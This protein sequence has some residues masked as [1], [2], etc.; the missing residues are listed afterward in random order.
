MT[1]AT[2]R[3][4]AGASNSSDTV[5]RFLRSRRGGLLAFVVLALVGWQVIAPLLESDSVPRPLETFAFM[6]DEIRGVT[7]APDNLYQ[8]FLITMRR[9]VIGFVIAVVIGVPIGLLMGLSR[10]FEA[11]FRDL[12]VILLTLPYLIWALVLS[13]WFGFT[14][15]AP[16]LT[17]VLSAVPFII[18]NVWEG[19]KDV[20]QDLLEMS[21]SYKM[22]RLTTLRHVIIPSQTPFL[23]AAARYGF[24]N[25]WKGVVVAEVF[26]AAAG[27]GWT[28]RYWYDA[29]RAYGVVG[30]AFFFV[31][32]SLILERVLFGK[33]S[34]YVFR[35]RPS[36]MEDRA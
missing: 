25:G 18:L 15:T 30:Y 24:A 10:R 23:F 27:A 32:F 19:V 33:L 21:R 22:S 34:K 35:W 20:P 36:V 26:G 13:M 31:I 5:R 17:V 2:A 4:V 8:A 28:I 7:L 3:P 1:E 16:I 12:V 29:H 9:L 14:D 11:Y 6:W